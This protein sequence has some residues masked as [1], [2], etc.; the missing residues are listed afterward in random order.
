MDSHR[1]GRIISA[2]L[3]AVRSG[4]LAEVVID[5][6]HYV[7]ARYCNGSLREWSAWWPAASRAHAAAIAPYGSSDV[8][9]ALISVAS[10]RPQPESA[11]GRTGAPLSESARD[12]YLVSAAGVIAATL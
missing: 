6:S 12:Y 8:P 4:D 9:A 10:W 1:P 5:S 2:D 7:Y 3:A 11:S